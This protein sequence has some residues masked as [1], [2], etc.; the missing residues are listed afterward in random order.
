M[1]YNRSKESSLKLITL[2]QTTLSIEERHG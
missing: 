1:S 2:D